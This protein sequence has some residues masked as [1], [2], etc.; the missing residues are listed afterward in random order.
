MIKETATVVAVD[1]D[2]ITVEAAIKTTCSSCQAQSDCGSGVISRAL[3]PR[4]QQLSLRSPV[5]CKVGDTVRIGVPEAGVVAASLWLYVVPLIVLVISAIGA[6]Q[7]LP[8]LGLNSEL[9]ALATSLL[10][11]F[12]S[13]I[14]I[15]GHLKKIDQTRF[16]PVILSAT[17]STPEI[18]TPQK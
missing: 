18:Y 1:G 5:P 10:L 11:T 16:Q 13:F 3:S 2:F 4:T 6:G 8:R 9:W 7:G 12:G 17:V 14:L 15:S